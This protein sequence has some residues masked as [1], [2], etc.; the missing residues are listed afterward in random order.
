LENKNFPYGCMP[1]RFLKVHTPVR[2]CRDYSPVQEPGICPHLK[3][4][5]YTCKS[6]FFRKIY[7]F[8]EYLTTLI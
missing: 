4:Y 8:K 3:V 2:Y 6:C 1:G 7:Q 5:H